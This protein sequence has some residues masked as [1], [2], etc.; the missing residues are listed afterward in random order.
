MSRKI[1]QILEDWAEQDDL[2]NEENLKNEDNPKNEDNS[3]N[4]GKPILKTSPK[5][6]MTPQMTPRRIS[7]RDLK[8]KGSTKNVVHSFVLVLFYISSESLFI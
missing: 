7:Y 3:K 8:V 1:R 4:E 6:K 2:K 5:M